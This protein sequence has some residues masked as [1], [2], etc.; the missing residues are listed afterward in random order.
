MRSRERSFLPTERSPGTFE[1]VGAGAGLCENRGMTWQ[2]QLE[3][4]RVVLKAAP[5]G[6][7]LGLLPFLASYH[8]GGRSLWRGLLGSFVFWTFITAFVCATYFA[9]FFGLSLIEKRFG[10]RAPGWKFHFVTAACG[11]VTG[12]ALTI[13]IQQWYFGAR[14]DQRWLFQ[15]LL[16]GGVLTGLFGLYHVAMEARAEMHKQRAALA[17]AR[18]HVL[19]TQLRPHF[20]FNALNSLAELIEARRDDAAEAVYTLA[21]LYRTILAS[22]KRRTAAL[23]AELTVVRDY[24]SLEKLRFGDRLAFTVTAPEHSERIFAPSLALLTLVEN[25]VKHGIAPATGGG[26][27]VVAVAPLPDGG[28]Q[29][30]VSNTGAPLKQAE[31]P[32]GTGLVNTRE[33]LDLLYGGSHGFNLFQSDGRTVAE[34]RFSGARID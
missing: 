32:G 18:L 10:P 9:A 6:I 12:F 30:R 24:L 5:F 7:L 23:D 20:L 2:T 26:I 4:M 3:R 19:E 15:A 34:F 31:R 17:D 28:F 11:M 29:A 13:Q 21:D 14:H 1:P 33:R 25:A 27:I 8:P 22:S 16:W